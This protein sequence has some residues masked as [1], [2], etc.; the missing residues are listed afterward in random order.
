MHNCEF[1][2]LRVKPTD[3]IN[4]HHHV[5]NF[6]HSRHNLDDSSE[7][8]NENH[9]IMHGHAAGINGEN[10]NGAQQITSGSNLCLTLSILLFVGAALFLANF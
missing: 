6:D 1:S 5:K 3:P 8:N 10:L 7:S 9:G 2:C 4:S